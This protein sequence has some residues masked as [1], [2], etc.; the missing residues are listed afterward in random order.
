M[1]FITLFLPGADN[2]DLGDLGETDNGAE[3][4]DG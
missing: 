1:F 3:F 2:G 4:E